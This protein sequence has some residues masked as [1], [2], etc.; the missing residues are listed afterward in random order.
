MGRAG[1]VGQAGLVTLAALLL[2]L[3]VG[4]Q[5]TLPPP[6]IDM[7]LHA[8]RAES[9][10]PP[11]LGFCTGAPF[12]AGSNTQPW[13][14][15]F[16][17]WF[18]HPPCANP[19]WSPTTDA[20]LR[21]RTLAV[22]RRRNVY[23]V[24]SG[25][26]LEDWR[27]PGGVRVIPSLAL[28]FSRP[29]PAIDAVRKA[30]AEHRYAALGE[31][32][33]QYQGAEPG[34]PRFEPYAALAE[35]LDIPLSIHVGTGPPGAPYLPGFD[36]YRARLHSPLLV[37]EL[38]LKHPKLRVNLMHAGWPMLDDLLAV[39]W[40]HPQV[41]VDVGII[42]YALP[43]AGFHTY[44]Q[45]IVEAGFGKRVLFGSDQMVWPE[46]IDTAIES[47]ET[48][49]FLSAE[50]KRDILYNNAARFLKLTGPEMAR[51]RTAQ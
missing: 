39:M 7:H 17:D 2:T 1:R 19:I 35:E 11:P 37:E 40:A 8:L 22:M 26:R 25:G 41:Y 47:I 49:P 23:G 5:T 4:A 31:V 14:E 6:I 34:D 48:A 16:L 28:D 36:K 50:Q 43:R 20:E 29:P 24:A 42:S 45:R 27:G 46:A 44:L 21:D 33:I 32:A 13:A 15:T 9:Q 10:G 38:L 18:K 3:Q 51:H 12:P 30:F